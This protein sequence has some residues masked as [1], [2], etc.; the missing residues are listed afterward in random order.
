[1]IYLDFE[2]FLGFRILFVLLRKIRELID[3]RLNLLFLVEKILLLI[4]E[5]I[6]VLIEGVVFLL[7]ID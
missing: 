3:L 7:A 2:D 5:R 1:M 6:D 4:P